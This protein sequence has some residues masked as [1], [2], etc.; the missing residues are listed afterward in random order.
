MCTCIQGIV[1]NNI[2]KQSSPHHQRD[3]KNDFPYNPFNPK[4]SLMIFH[5]D[6]YTIPIM[7]AVADPGLE[8][9]GPPVFCRGRFSGRGVRGREVEG[10]FK[11]IISNYHI[12][13][14]KI[15][16]HNFHHNTMFSG[17]TLKSIILKLSSIA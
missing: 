13:I 3:L 12:N 5:I 10:L 7:L 17:V 2:T 4:I 11:A 1:F 15:F 8:L 14:V 9:R 6:C 16:D